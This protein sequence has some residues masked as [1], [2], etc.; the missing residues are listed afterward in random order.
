[1]G[2]YWK[3]QAKLH[4][5]ASIDFWEYAIPLFSK[6]AVSF[7]KIDNLEEGQKDEGQQKKIDKKREQP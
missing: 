4:L 6:G 2:K 7:M 5:I 1:M 3:D